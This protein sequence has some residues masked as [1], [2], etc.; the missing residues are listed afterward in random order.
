MASFSNNELIRRVTLHNDNYKLDTTNKEIVLLL[1]NGKIKIGSDTIY[2]KNVFDESP[3]GFYGANCGFYTVEGI[4]KTEFCIIEGISQDHVIAI[5]GLSNTYAKKT[6]KFQLIKSKNI[7]SKDVGTASF[8]REVKT[9]IDSKSG[10][11][12]LIVGET[13]KSAGNWSSWPPHKHDCYVKGKESSQKEIY[14]YKFKD[15]KG[16]GIQLR[17]KDS[18]KADSA[19][20]VKNNDE[21]KIKDGYHPVVSCPYSDMYYLWVLFGN[22]S[23]FKVNY[24][25]Q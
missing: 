24:E 19:I 16:F 8:S 1:L 18:L 13:K 23:F 12:N 5:D 3:V 9:I 15:K 14:L 2:R 17:Y 25:S 11:E 22:N 4:G 10:L 21:V 20:V 7:T 6:I